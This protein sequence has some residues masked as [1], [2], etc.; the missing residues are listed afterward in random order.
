MLELI[1]DKSLLEKFFRRNTLLNVYQLGDLD[2]F[3][4]KE[5]D[6]YGTFQNGE[7]KSVVLVYKEALPD[8]VIALA[9]ESE[10]NLLKENLSELLSYLPEKIYLHITPGAE[11][12]LENKYEL[13]HEGLYWKMNLSDKSK[14]FKVNTDDVEQLTVK[15]TEELADFYFE[16]YPSNSFNVRMLKTGMYYGLKKNGKIVSAAGIHVYS[17]NYKVAAL[18]NITTHP[19][20]CGKGY[21][22][23]VTAKLCMELFKNTEVIGLNVHSENSSAIHCYENLGFSKIADYLEITGI[24]E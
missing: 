17:P 24:C 18:G 19:A 2:D 6:F 4:W 15:D 1:K 11:K 16:S 20:H 21:A 14:L 9:G 10:I 7:L 13:K 3:Y 8:V 23:K 22:Q 5:T 12:I